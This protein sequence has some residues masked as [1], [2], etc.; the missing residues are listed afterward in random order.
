MFYEVLIFIFCCPIAFF[1]MRYVRLGLLEA[2]FQSRVAI[3][4]ISLATF[5]VA[6]LGIATGLGGYA[7]ATAD[8][9][10]QYSTALQHFILPMAF[11]TALLVQIAYEAN[12]GDD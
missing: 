10:P 11:V 4:T 7:L 2:G 6:G 3:L 8:G 5:F 12:T 1:I 9:I